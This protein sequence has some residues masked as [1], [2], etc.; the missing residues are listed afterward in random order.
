MDTEFDLAKFDSYREDNRLEVKSAS[1]GLPQS[2]WDTYSSMANT[3]GGAIICGVKE[4]KD[5]SWYTTGLSASDIPKLMKEFWDLINNHKKVSINLLK[6]SDLEAYSVND[7][8]VL[9]IKVPAANREHKP[10]YLNNDIFGGSFKRNH[11]GDY[12]C[13]ADEVR[14]MI[15]DQARQSSDA[16][17]LLTEEIADLDAESVKSYRVWFGIQHAD[18]A[19]TKLPDEDFLEMVGAAKRA[20][21]GRIHP[22]CAGL[23]M[24]GQEHRIAYEY[25][26][27]FLDYRDH[28]D[29]RVRW[30]DRIQSQSPDWSGNVFDF[31]SRVSRKLLLLLKVPFKLVN[32]VRVDETPMHDA[33]REALVNCLANADFFL[34]RGIVIDSYPDRIVIKNPGTSIVG[35]RQ[36]LRG[37]ESEPRNVNIMKMFNL[38]GF[39]E[40]A[41]SGIPDIYSVWKSSGYMEPTIEEHFGEDGPNKTVITLPLIEKSSDQAMN[42]A[43]PE[44]GLEKGLEKTPNTDISHKKQNMD[45][46]VSSVYSLIL[47][48]P[49]ISQIAIANELKLSE[50]QVRSALNKLR[51]SGRIQR[52]GSAR[53]GK[54]LIIND[55]TH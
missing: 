11:E 22:T 5:R 20:D 24:F 54:W 23:L 15:R 28:A 29:L 33:V 44:K 13:T 46:R 48:N 27:Y 21:D 32:T 19:W 43:L 49:S 14:A 51:E 35:K 18:H 55:Q 17:V 42:Q 3:Y 52:E 4:R 37:G 40:H 9:V 50:K 30:T 10:V 2:L 47:A 12:H 53:G 1:G 41:G 25:P 8:A 39:G 6:E 45:N 26:S 16:K 31:Y 36:M 38:L 7:H 34:P